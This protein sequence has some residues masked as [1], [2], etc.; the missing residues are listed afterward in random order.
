[1]RFDSAPWPVNSVTLINVLQSGRVA[2]I[3]RF[4]ADPEITEGR[5]SRVRLCWIIGKAVVVCRIRSVRKENEPQEMKK[6]SLSSCSPGKREM[7]HDH[8]SQRWSRSTKGYNYS[9]WRMRLSLARCYILFDA[10]CVSS[11]S[12]L[13]SGCSLF[14]YLWMSRC[15]PMTVTMSV[16]LGSIKK[17]K[18]HFLSISA[19]YLLQL[20]IA[21]YHVTLLF[22]KK[23]ITPIVEQHCQRLSKYTQ[24]ADIK[25]NS[26]E[27]PSNRMSKIFLPVASGQLFLGWFESGSRVI[28]ANRG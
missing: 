13:Y 28:T 14:Q 4:S 3:S 15:S 18:N 8:V 24:R 11:L 2:S 16:Q 6:A 19:P 5:P 22:D 23:A 17:E 27:D 12:N 9:S 7:S 26:F 10:F 21:F 1:M 25:T 20:F